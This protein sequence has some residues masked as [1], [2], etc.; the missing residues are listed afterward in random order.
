MKVKGEKCKGSLY[1]KYHNTIFNLRKSGVEIAKQ[2]T[3][4]KLLPSKL[5]VNNTNLSDG[6][7]IYNSKYKNIYKRL[8][9]IVEDALCYRSWLK[10]NIDPFDEVIK[11]WS[12]TFSQRLSELN[13]E[14]P[15]L[16]ILDEWPSYKQSFG[17]SLVSS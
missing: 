16:K 3:D 14:T 7:C 5:Q 12:F 11:K 4:K 10:Y 6:K 9:L 13:S 8:L 17:H 1:S 2:R 15:L